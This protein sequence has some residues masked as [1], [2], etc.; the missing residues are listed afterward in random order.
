MVKMASGQARRS[1]CLAMVLFRYF[2]WG[3]MQ[4]NFLR[5]AKAC[6]A[7]GHRVD[8]YTLGWEG[9][10]AEGEGASGGGGGTLRPLFIRFTNYIRNNIC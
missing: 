10:Q 1:L 9:G 2:P 8:V 7:R 4:A 5:I 6:L 3:G